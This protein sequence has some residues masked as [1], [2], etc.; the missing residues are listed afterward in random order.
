MTRQKQLRKSRNNRVISGVCGGI[1]EYVGVDPVL[2]RV[3][4]VI[5]FFASAGTIFLGYLLLLLIMP[6]A[7]SEAGS[8]YVRPSQRRTVEVPVRS[9]RDGRKRKNDDDDILHYAR[10]LDEIDEMRE[11]SKRKRH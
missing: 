8:Y 9:D 11:K 2:I 4:F 5:G 6:N 1:G 10:P 7:S 3:A